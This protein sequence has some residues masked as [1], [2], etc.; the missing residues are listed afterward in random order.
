MSSSGRYTEAELKKKTSP[1]VVKTPAGRVMVVQENIERLTTGNLRDLMRREGI[2]IPKSGTGKGGSVLKKDL[3]LVITDHRARTVGGAEVVIPAPRKIPSP[4]KTPTAALKKL[5]VTS[6]R[7]KC[8]ELGLAECMDKKQLGKMKKDELIRLIRAAETGLA[9]PA[10]SPA[11]SPK[12]RTP[13]PPPAMVE[14]AKMRIPARYS[15][16]S[17][18]Q[19]QNMCKFRGIEAEKCRLARDE[20]IAVLM[21][22]ERL[23]EEKRKALMKEKPKTPTPK[24]KIPSPAKKA[25][26]CGTRTDPKCPPGKICDV[27]TGSCLT[28]TKAG[29]G[30][31]AREAREKKY[32]TEYYFDDEHGLVG[33]KQDVLDHLKYWG[34]L[35]KIPTPTPKRKMPTPKKTPTPKRKTPTPKKC[36][37]KEDPLLCDEGEICSALSGKCI[38][39]TARNRKD[40][41]VLITDDGRTIVGA[42]KTIEKLHSALGGTIEAPGKKPSPP[43]KAKIPTTESGL[44]KRIRELLDEGGEDEEIGRLR[45]ALE[46]MKKAKSKKTSPAGKRKTS[47]AGKRKPP[48]KPPSYRLQASKQDIAVTFANCIASL[49]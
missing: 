18:K 24:R 2:P 8:R 13:I 40:R 7:R 38:K 48:P 11:P 3:I 1:K 20:L 23:P 19:L 34:L 4:A 30:K 25:Y 46:A 9:I 27:D 49:T 36:T 29:M 28:R 5:K 35:P 32:G 15:S 47:P 43:K 37:D 12:A 17:L 21:E 33:R 6:L 39:D 22:W 42:Q 44:Q 41:Y 10:P 14:I 16:R 31:R 26:K 45:D